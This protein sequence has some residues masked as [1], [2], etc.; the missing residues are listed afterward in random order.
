V[1]L[2]EPLPLGRVIAP[3]RLMFGPHVTNLGKGRALSDRHVAYYA[4]RAGGGAGII[5]TETASV[6]PWDWPY[7]R[8]PL[9]AECEPGWAAIA[10]ACMPNGSV[11]L[12]SLGHSGG[13]GS[14]AYSQRELWAPSGV[15]EVNTREMPKVMEA[16]DIAAVIEGFA[17]AAALAAGAGLAGVEIDAGSRSLVRQFLS[18]LTNTRPDDYGADRLM[19]ARE[20]LTAVRQALADAVA[21][22][23]ARGDAAHGRAGQGGTDRGGTASDGA[24][25]EGS[26]RRAVGQG[27]AGRGGAAPDVAAHGAAQETAGQG[28]PGGGIERGRPPG[29]GQGGA[30]LGLRLCC[31][32][33]APW[34]GITPERAAEIAAALAPLVD[35]LVVVRGSIYSAAA[36]RP[37]CHTEP[38]FNLALARRIRDAAGGLADGG[39][40]VFAQGSIVG[41]AMAEEA[42]VT[43]CC[44]GVEMTRAQIADAGLGRKLAARAAGMAGAAPRPCILC[45]QACQVLDSRNPIVSCVAD[46]RAGHETED[47][48]V[49]G[50]PSETA[51]SGTLD[52]SPSDGTVRGPVDGP[53]DGTAKTPWGI[54]GGSALGMTAY[55]LYPYIPLY[56]PIRDSAEP[57]SPNAPGGNALAGRSLGALDFLVIGGGPA[58]LEAARAAATRGHRVRLAEAR[59]RL[60][61]DVV[62]AAAAPGRGS[63]T[64]LTAWLENECRRLGVEITLGHRVTVAEVTAHDGPVVV[65]TGS[66]DGDPAY[67]IA[68]GGQ[69]ISA[70]DFLAT[71]LPGDTLPSDPGNPHVENRGDPPPHSPARP[72]PD[73]PDRPAPDRPLPARPNP[74]HPLSD[75]PEGLLPGRLL[76]DGPVLV[77]DP[78]GGPIGVSVA[79]FLA[80]RVPTTLAFPDQIPGQQLALTGDLVAANA[81]LQSAG[82]TLVRRCALRRVAAGHAEVEDA[83][84]A[85]A[86]VLSAD[87]VIDAGPRLPAPLW[88]DSSDGAGADDA[89][90]SRIVVAGDAVAPRTIYQAILEGR[91]AVLSLE[92]AARQRPPARAG[93]PR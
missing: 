87:L 43:G 62:I 16:E 37:D 65:A 67:E 64:A 20:V 10:Q 47:E 80:P 23:T 33:L 13:Q 45:N 69:V 92:R 61:G 14:S 11:V 46:P 27:S 79:E 82:V 73:T 3:G 63:L 77:W 4:R 75:G 40:P 58:G 90:T 81:R 76:P 44:D 84:G 28:A 57:G 17:A 38:G 34:A 39:V 50:P 26:G 48:P 71:A 93:A 21:D 19:F 72:L 18:G 89:L 5:V 2:L 85:G 91:R 12:A 55:P 49:D 68:D 36:T 60:G 31:D 32:E 42:I 88:P 52:G 56:I 86:Q 29:Q 25:Q 24:G 35:Y 66:R 51:A 15:P 83:F 78:V 70:R 59:E 8:A 7:E 53:A 9:A 41:P 22:N 54:R 74:V 6:H 30:I 1:R